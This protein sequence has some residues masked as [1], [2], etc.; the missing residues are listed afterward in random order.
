VETAMLKVLGR[1]T[2]IN[3]RKVLWTAEEIGLA[4]EREDWGKPI[5]DPNV[6]EFL[7]LNPNAQ[8]PVIIDDGVVLWESHAILRYLAEMSASE[9][10]PADPRE[11]ALVDQWM[12]WQASELNPSWSYVVPALLRND[13]PNPDPARLAAGARAWTAKMEILEAQLTGRR[14]V[15][16]DRFSLADIVLALST[17]R[18]LSLAFDKPRLAAVE[19]HCVEMRQRKAGAPYL[20]A[21]TP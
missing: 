4:Y 8:V 17:H 2:S 11:R 19:A 9:L 6:P 7:A 10:Y 21:A 12:S 15:A 16:N 20:G 3:V 14:F 1:V 18:W 13:P 5:R